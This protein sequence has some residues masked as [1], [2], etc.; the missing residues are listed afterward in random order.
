[1]RNWVKTWKSAVSLATFA[2]AIA[3]GPASE[4]QN[5]AAVPGG[6]GQAADA[7]AAQALQLLNSGKLQDAEAGYNDILQRYP[8]SGVVPE[9]EFRLGYIQYAEGNYPLAI[10]TLKRIKSPPATP[11]IK[12]AGDALIPQVLAAQAA[13]MQP[14]DPGRK[15][16]FNNAISGFD[17]IIKKSPNSTAAQS[18]MY[19]RASAS[20]Q[21][22]DYYAATRTLREIVRKFPNGESFLDSE[23]L[24]AV[25]LIAD[26]NSIVARHGDQQAA[27]MKFSEALKYLADVIQR[28][29]DVALANDAQYQIGEVLFNRAASEQGDARTNDLT[30]AI[31]AYRAVQPKASMV[32][33]QQARLDVVT[34]RQRQVAAS[35]DA[36]QIQAVQRVMDRENAKMDAI[37]N[38]PDVTVGAQLRIASCYYML[39]KYDEARVML[40]YLQPFATD[41]GQKKQIA[42]YLV[43]S[44]AAQGITAK[45]DAAYNDFLNSYRGADPLAENL[46]LAMGGAFLTGKNKDIKKAISYFQQEISNYPNS[47]YVNEALAQEAAA[48]IDSKDYDN[49]LST[50]QKYL[51]TNPPAAQAAGAA[52]G[53]AEIYQ[54][55]GKLP[56]AIQEYQ[57][58]A[59]KYPGT[60]GAEQCAFYAAGLQISV[61]PKKALDGL[62]NYVK[63]YPT[64]QFAAQALMMIGQVQA[65]SGDNASAMETFK[66]V[67][68]KFP[69]SDFGPQAYFQQAAILGKQGKTD[70]M[71]KTLRDFLAAYP[72][73]KDIFYAYDTIGQTQITQGKLQDAIA[74]YT[75]MAEQ[76]ADNAMAPSA[77][78]R[79]ADLWQKQAA[80]LGEYAGLSDAKKKEWNDDVAKSIAAGETLLQKYPESDQVGVALKTLLADQEMMVNA[81]VKKPGD[82]DD[83]F[84]K[85]AGRFASNASAKSRILFTLAT[86]TYKT[87]PV[88]AVAQMADA[89]DASLVYAPEDMDLYGQALLEQ[90]K[91]EE[92]YKIYA[93]VAKDY[94]VP[95]NAQPAQATPAIQQAQALAL[96]GMASALGDQ[97]KTDEA[98][99][100]FA[101][102]KANYPWSTKVVEANFGIAKA[103][104][105]Q[106]SFDPAAKLLVSI[107]ANRNAPAS[108]RAHAFLLVGDIQSAKGNITAAID[109][110]LKTAAFYG[111]VEDAASEGLWK[112]GQALEQ[113]AET[114]NEATTP[115]KS[116][117]IGKAVDAYKNI[118]ANFA[119]SKYVQQAQDRITALGGH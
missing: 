76:H 59:Q 14:D 10:E 113:Q 83:Y 43:L 88:R 78:Y 48:L 74:T 35:R 75:E 98:G 41:D 32:T 94:P 79:P 90:G 60:P 117:Q 71:I 103:L 73:N 100:L 5:Q 67:V 20:F 27:L 49:A 47:P 58:V 80:A 22:E 31:A 112:G 30:N 114:L 61:D 99:K 19:G 82:L 17:E 70:D 85:L 16:A 25:V 116:E 29:T 101:Q 97:G 4:A 2:T 26:A 39:A 102:L 57:M 66:Q 1:M 8:N 110:Y 65:S 51:D 81:K 68:D 87:D 7:A 77:L 69:Q 11:E 53:I 21:M 96:F 42:Y 109:T 62:Q 104:V 54:E 9:A 115:K 111:G 24:L 50:Y 93:K 38:A 72:D 91:A 92:A 34:Q 12:A 64:G 15:D 36:N 37:K 18:A 33:A 55:T 52:Q 3:S 107:V 56:E 28:H 86:H 23:D 44:Y 6:I 106:K 63:T 46:P 119:D 95:P 118:V 108:L 105:K 45:A 40:E 84:H 13:K 89:Y